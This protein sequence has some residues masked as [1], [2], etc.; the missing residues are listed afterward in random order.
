METTTLL[1][2]LAALLMLIGLAGTV[3]PALPGMPILFG[4]MLLAAWVGDFERIG[5][6]TLVL[7]GGLTALALALDFIAGLLGAKRVGASGLALFGAALGTLIG[8]FFGLFGLVIGPF[9]GAVLGELANGKQAA[10]AAKVGFGT[11]IGM[12]LG[13]VAKVGIAFVMLGVFLF[14]LA[15]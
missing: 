13:A 5:A 11:W 6:W 9:L 4:G 12:A 14:A 10:D 8:L 2:A 15:V 1:Y 3:L 7:L